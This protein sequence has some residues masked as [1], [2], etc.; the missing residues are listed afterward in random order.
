MLVQEKL[1]EKSIPCAQ[2][3][4]MPWVPPFQVS[5]SQGIYAP[6][7]PHSESL[8][9]SLFVIHW[10][11]HRCVNKGGGGGVVVSVLYSQKKSKKIPVDMSMRQWS[12][13]VIAACWHVAVMVWWCWWCCVVI[14][15]G[16]GGGGGGC[17]WCS[18][19]HREGDRGKKERR[20]VQLHKVN[21]IMW[22][23]SFNELRKLSNF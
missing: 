11:C 21:T 23:R 1:E 2:G 7:A 20:E 17:F 19:G 4:Y 22:C 14:D 16:G 13:V 15:S 5:P 10:R 12:V 18:Y 9:S 8:L 6:W 3:V